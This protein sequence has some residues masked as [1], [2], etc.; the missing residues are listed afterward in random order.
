MKKEIVGILL[1]LT[2][3]SVSIETI[4]LNAT[5]QIQYFRLLAIE[6]LAGEKTAKDAQ[7]L[8]SILLEYDNW[9]NKTDRYVS[10]IHFLSTCNESEI[11]PQCR[12]YYRG[13]STKQNLQHEIVDFLGRATPNE[14]V[15]FCYSGLGLELELYLGKA[16]NYEVIN[17]NELVSWFSSGGLPQANVCVILDCCHAGSWIDD[18]SGGVL[19]SGR[20]VLAGC[21]SDQMCGVERPDDPFGVFT[22]LREADYY[23]GT[24]GPVGIIGALAS[25]IN[26]NGDGWVSFQETFDFAKNTVEQK[27]HN[28]QNPVSYNGLS[29]DPGFVLLQLPEPV[30]NFT[31]SPEIAW[32]NETVTF[33]ATQSHSTNGNI[34]SYEWN[35]DDGNTTTVSV[36]TI[37][38]TYT[39]EGNYTVTLKVT[40]EELSNSTLKTITI[41]FRTDL[42]KDGIVNILDITIVAVAWTPEGTTPDHPRWNPIADLDKNSIVNIIDIAKVA[43]DYQKTT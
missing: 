40:D 26:P 9:N 29:F 1:V 20:I 21:R 23:N 19:G 3:M 7:R 2:L 32:V 42:N 5:I 8:I 22:G 6:T 27:T 33:N 24:I 13:D 38:H 18:G 30:A 16:P 39:K 15:V 35:F 17:S 28:L 37:N 25:G 4:P 34:T 41:T 36:P 12:D 31:Y 11:M 14:I 10:H 43:A